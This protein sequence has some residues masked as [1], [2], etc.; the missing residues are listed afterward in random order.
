VGVSVLKDGKPTFIDL[1]CGAGGMS[2]GFENAGWHCVAGVDDDPESCETFNRNHPNSL[3][4]RG[5][6]HDLS[7][8]TEVDAIV[9]GFPCPAHSMSGRRLGMA[10]ERGKVF[11]GVARIIGEVKPKVVVYENVKGILSSKDEEGN[12]GGA[13]KYIIDATE[14]LGYTVSHKVLNANHYGVPQARERWILVGTLSGEVWD[15]PPPIFPRPTVY[16]AFADLIEMDGEDIDLPNHVLSS[17]GQEMVDKLKELRPGDPLYPQYPEGRMRLALDEPAKTIKEN[18]GGSP[19]HPIEHRGTTPREMAR[20]QSFPDD[21]VFLG[22][23]RSWY[24]QIGNAVPVRFA[25][26]IAE[27]V[28]GLL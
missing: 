6:V 13:L 27:S 22:S 8:H 25:Q 21:F 18:H 12:K 16:D 11:D 28:R 17:H 15:P 9:S 20:L 4:V 26:A 2:L 10:D 7:F 23:R 5:S 19:I 1:C 14:G 24:V 3:C